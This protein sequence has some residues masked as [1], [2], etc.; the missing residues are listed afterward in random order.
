[1]VSS[2]NDVAA[3]SRRRRPAR[4]ERA[5]L[6]TA[7]FRTHARPLP[8]RADRDPYRIW[9]A[10]VLL[11]QTRVA[12][13]TGRF[14]AFLDRF[15][16][17]AALAAASEE[18]VLKA[19]EG[20]GYYARAR[21]LREAARAL[22]DEHGGELPRSA[23]ELEQ[24]P[25]FGP[26]IANAVASLAF[27]EPVVALEANGIRVA[28]RW[29]G[30]AGDVRVPSVRA[31]LR[32]ALEDELPPDEAGTFN[33]ALM[34]LGE[35]VCRPKRPNCPA[36]PVAAS[37]RARQDLPDPGLLPRRG[38]RPPTPH[39][40]AAVVALSADGRWLVRRRPRTG[41]LGGLWELPGGRVE[42][43]ETM[44]A[45]AARELHEETGL[46]APVLEPVGVVRHAYSHFSV[47]LHVFRG[48]LAAPAAARG[49]APLRW[50]TR[51]EFERLPRP[52]ATVRAMELLD[53]GRGATSPDSGS[54][55]G[56]RA[57]STRAGAARRRD[58]APAGR[59][60]ASGSRR[61]A[62]R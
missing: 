30:E 61:R 8:W 25:G 4:F 54:R 59:T 55:P 41:L 28:A 60:P 31:R 45:A 34:E 38:P 24:L 48:A 32:R 57:T 46:V 14:A 23:R 42:P 50:V 58:R 10:E 26:Y 51:E 53:R 19:W 17:V 39:V 5:R 27:G 35:T 9:V 3:S 40:V 7:W 21:H 20:A 62:R 13:V 47:E 16:T 43:G 18:D 49:D 36:C 56:R 11:Q 29:T 12:A 37:C 1:M 15:P 52:T 2:R 33:E 44:V 22:V 6:L